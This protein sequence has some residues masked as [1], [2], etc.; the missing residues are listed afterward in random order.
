MLDKSVMVCCAQKYLD[1]SQ[2]TL[3]AGHDKEK[4]LRHH[5]AMNGCTWNT[6]HAPPL[7]VTGNH[8]RFFHF[9][10][11]LNVE[12]LRRVAELTTAAG[13]R[14]NESKASLVERISMCF[15]P[16]EAMKGSRAYLK[17]CRLAVWEALR[18]AGLPY[19]S[20]DTEN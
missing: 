11:G 10:Y 9:L 16:D 14:E 15:G 13:L 17:E 6:G 8:R 3:P 5:V 20:Q 2:C 12:Q 1:G 18:T 7:S 4:E 19:I